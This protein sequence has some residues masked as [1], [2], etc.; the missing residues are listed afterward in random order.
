MSHQQQQP[1]RDSGGVGVG[2]VG[3]AFPDLHHKMSKK[4]AQLTKVIYHLNSKNEMHEAEVQGVQDLYE[5]EIDEVRCSGVWGVVGV[6]C[7]AVCR[8]GGL[9]LLHILH[10]TCHH[11]YS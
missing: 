1:A 11:F 4:I 2:S 10:V 3:G 7:V 5:S 9:G 6:M 8:C